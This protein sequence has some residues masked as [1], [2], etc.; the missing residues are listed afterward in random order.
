M[1]IIVMGVSGCGKSTIGQMLAER[2][3]LPFHDADA[4]H[5]PENRQKMAQDMPLT[6]ADRWPWLA[7]LSTL[8]LSWEAQGGAVLACSALKQAYREVLVSHA[9]DSHIVY[10]ELSRPAA[11]R[12]LEG[13][14]GQHEFVG[15]FARLL[16]GQYRDLEPP[17]FA[18]TVNAELR[19]SEI[20]ELAFAALVP[21]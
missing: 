13:R 8:A 10:L 19:P 12:R 14:R 21:H 2:L 20:V 1:F 3:E 7:R 6:D 17:T 18:I 4:Y 15:E 16:D 9:A 11:A 5:S